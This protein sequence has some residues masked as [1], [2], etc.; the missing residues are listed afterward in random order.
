M[1]L[2]QLGRFKRVEQANDRGAVQCQR[3]SKVLLAHRRRGASEI[4]QG[5]P[6]S[7][8][9]AKWLQPAIDGTPPLP[10]RAGHEGPETVAKLL[11]TL[12]HGTTRPMTYQYMQYHVLPQDLQASGWER[13]GQ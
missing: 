4:D 10:G 13:A 8:G 2:D 11:S 7:F 12:V 6:G 5:E 3:G 9:E 1:A